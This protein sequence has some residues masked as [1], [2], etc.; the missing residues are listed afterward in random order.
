MNTPNRFAAAAGVLLALVSLSLIPAAGQNVSF[1]SPKDYTVGKGP[2]A[3][4][5][6]DFN[7]DG[8][9]DIAVTDDSGSSVSVLLGDGKGGLPA[10]EELRGRVKSHGDGSWRFQ[11]R[12]QA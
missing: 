12:W 1:N 3:L 8:N 2:Q 10:R 4:V 6:S 7:L 5:V 9:L 11:P